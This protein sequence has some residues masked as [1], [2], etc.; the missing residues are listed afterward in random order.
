[1]CECIAWFAAL[2]FSHVYTMI[3][4]TSDGIWC[5]GGRR[6][7]AASC[8]RNHHHVRL[9]LEL[10]ACELWILFVVFFS[11]SFFSLFWSLLIDTFLSMR[12]FYPSI[13]E[14]EKKIRYFFFDPVVWFTDFEQK[15]S[16]RFFEPDHTSQNQREKVNENTP[17]LSIFQIISTLNGTRNMICIHLMW[18]NQAQVS[19][20]SSA[21][22]EC[23]CIYIYKVKRSKIAYLSDF[24]VYRKLLHFK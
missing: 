9:L 14:S 8:V 2:S 22:S 6:I 11:I 13:E 21:N 16:D 24:A 20:K 7:A 12:F 19:R 17:N 3:H 10:T 4:I 5:K 23:K 18:K 15:K 1:M